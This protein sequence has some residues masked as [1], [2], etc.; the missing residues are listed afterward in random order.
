MRQ[1]SIFVSLRIFCLVGVMTPIPARAAEF[2]TD[3]LSFFYFEGAKVGETIP[4]GARV[5]LKIERRDSGSWQITIDA[6]SVSVPPIRYPS[7]KTVQWK[8]GGVASGTLTVWD[9][10]GRADITVPLVAYVDGSDVGFPFPL[11][12]TT[13]TTVAMASGVTASREGARLDPSSGVI[14]LVAAGVSPP[15]APTA[16]GK[17]FYVVVSGQIIDLPEGLRLK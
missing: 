5:P 9:G 10:K 17:P 15:T 6:S 16:P 1:T 8:L 11:T 13:E 14:Q 4:A 7:G 2:V 12:F 3:N